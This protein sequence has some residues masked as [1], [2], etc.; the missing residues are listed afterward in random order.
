MSLIQYMRR[1]YQILRQ[2]GHGRFDALLQ[3]VQC[4]IRDN[5]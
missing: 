1:D 4:A 2:C 5:T 3:T